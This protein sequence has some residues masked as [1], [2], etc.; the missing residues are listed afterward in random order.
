MLC[1]K[2]A[3]DDNNDKNNDSIKHRTNDNKRSCFFPNF[4]SKYLSQRE[5]YYMPQNLCVMLCCNTNAIN[6]L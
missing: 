5:L 2:Y 6:C 4:I 3:S 1:L